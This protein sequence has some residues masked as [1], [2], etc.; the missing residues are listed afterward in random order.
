MSKIASFRG[1]LI[2]LNKNKQVINKHLIY[3]PTSLSAEAF[4]R[5]RIG[6]ECTIFKMVVENKVKLLA[7]IRTKLLYYTNSMT[8]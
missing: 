7:A 4:L 1:S 5:R 3:E 2:P 6:G 8:I